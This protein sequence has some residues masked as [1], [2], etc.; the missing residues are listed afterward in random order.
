MYLYIARE[1]QIKA[2]SATK[3]IYL[4]DKLN[5]K[6]RDLYWDIIK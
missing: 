5:P 6:W 3:K 4:I 2:G 1:K